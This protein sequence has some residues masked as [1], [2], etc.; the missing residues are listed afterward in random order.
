[1][2]YININQFLLKSFLLYDIP[3]TF[4]DLLVEDNCVDTI[5]FN[6]SVLSTTPVDSIINPNSLYDSFILGKLFL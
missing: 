6:L 1:L 2:F 3:Y 4:E 5:V